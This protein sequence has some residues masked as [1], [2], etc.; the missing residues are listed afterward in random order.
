[1]TPQPFS[2]KMVQILMESDRDKQTVSDA[3]TTLGA[4]YVYQMYGNSEFFTACIPEDRLEDVQKITFIRGAHLP[5][6]FALVSDSPKSGI[7][8]FVR[9][10][11][12][13]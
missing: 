11:F 6:R 4:K 12:R 3:L 1:M 10:I 9:G 13:G 8:S 7:F 5:P 2:E